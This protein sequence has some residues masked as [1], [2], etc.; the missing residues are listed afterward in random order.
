MTNNIEK[1]LNILKLE[2]KS[3]EE[4][5]IRDVIQAYRKLAKNLHPDKS[6]YASKEEFQDLGEAYEHILKLVV[7]G[8]KRNGDTGVKRNEKEKQEDE[9]TEEKFVKDNFHNFNFPTEKEGSFVVVLE[10]DLAD[11]WD[12]CFK[13]IYGEPKVNRTRTGTETSRLWR[14]VYQGCELT[15]HL[16]KKPKTTKI[17]KFLVQGGN[18]VKKYFFVFTE[19]PL[20]YKKV[21]ERKIPKIETET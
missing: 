4:L 7:E 9:E 17:S 10:N 5:S 14:I 13:D 19:L 11:A 20:I 6:G 21:C 12:E 8:T 16:Y 2:G 3:L 1:Y 15:I 18:H